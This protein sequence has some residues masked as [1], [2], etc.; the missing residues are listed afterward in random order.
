MIVRAHQNARGLWAVISN[1]EV[2]PSS[3]LF[4]Q[5]EKRLRTKEK[6][7]NNLRN[8]DLLP[9]SV[10]KKHVRLSWVGFKNVKLGQLLMVSKQMASLPCWKPQKIVV[11]STFKSNNSSK[12]HPSRCKTGHGYLCTSLIQMYII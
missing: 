3:N 4:C 9:R 7:K 5:S 11:F 12:C 1:L 6:E 2:Q 10:M 8:L